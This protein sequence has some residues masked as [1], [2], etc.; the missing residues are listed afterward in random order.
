MS[1]NF[2][3]LALLDGVAYAA[4]LFL[5]AVGLTLIFGVLGIL[6]I[7]HGSLYAIGA[8]VT[9]TAGQWLVEQGYNPWLTFPL[10][11]VAAVAVGVVLGGSIEKL[12]L[13]RIYSKEPILQLLVTFAV[14]MI[15][16]N[17]QRMIWGC[18]PISC[19]RR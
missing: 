15:L 9:A 11:I 18:S 1:M 5:V 4:L 12:L 10:L 17:L 3:A 8:Y 19:P 16:E 13:A 6:N 14:F 2:A 7:A